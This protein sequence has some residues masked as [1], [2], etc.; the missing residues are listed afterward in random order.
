MSSGYGIWDIGFWVLGIGYWLFGIACSGREFH[1][2]L[3]ADRTLFS[4]YGF[5]R[6]GV[7]AFVVYNVGDRPTPTLEVSIMPMA[8]R[9]RFSKA[10]TS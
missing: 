8:V 6:M 10:M 4:S 3:W 2:P 1:Q 9:E 5:P 7:G